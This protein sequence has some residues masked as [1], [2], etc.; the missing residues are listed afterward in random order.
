MTAAV[1]ALAVALVTAGLVVG[2][3]RATHHEAARTERGYLAG[4]G[5][6]LDV[7]CDGRDCDTFNGDLVTT[8]VCRCQASRRLGASRW[9]PFLHRPSR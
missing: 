7:V 5:S 9:R 2:V 8:E 4:V 3:R 6:P 1:L